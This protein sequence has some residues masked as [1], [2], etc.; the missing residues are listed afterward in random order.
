[1]LSEEKTH[2]YEKKEEKLLLNYSFISPMG[3]IFTEVWV[4]FDFVYIPFL[5]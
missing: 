3:K 5:S 4:F 1:M 2:L